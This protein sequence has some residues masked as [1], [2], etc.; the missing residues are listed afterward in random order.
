VTAAEVLENEERVVAVVEA[1]QFW[2]P[3]SGEVLVDVL[4]AA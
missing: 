2:A 4:L 3:G 1:E